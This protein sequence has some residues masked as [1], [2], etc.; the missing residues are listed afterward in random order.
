MTT[1]S[2][3]HDTPHDPAVPDLLGM[4]VAHRAMLRDLR[5]TAVLAQDLSAGRTAATRRR[6]RAFARYLDL[7]ADSI[8]R[9][10]EAEDDILWPVIEKRAGDQVDL[11]ELSDDHS[12]LD[13]KLARLR[14]AAADL[15]ANPASEEAAGTLAL[16]L[17]QLRDLLV[18]HIEDE[19][20]AVFPVILR[21]LTV[22]DWQGVEAGIRKHGMNLGFEL[23]R[24]VDNVTDDEL[25][26]MKAQANVVL[27]LVLRIVVPRYRR[28]ERAVFSTSAAAA[29]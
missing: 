23:P 5:R 15:V 20:R 24:I 2:P 25:E 9:H 14:A 29:L 28:L 4:Q 10:H 3:A 6:V 11:S 21:H 8:H 18:E 16:Q 26:R 27:R 1:N 19:E 12:V 17:A 13:P 7:L 22:Q